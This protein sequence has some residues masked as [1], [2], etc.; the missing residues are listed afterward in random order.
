MFSNVVLQ[1][2]HD[3]IPT[4]VIT[5]RKFEPQGMSIIIRKQKVKDKVPYRISKNLCKLQLN[6][7]S[8]RCLVC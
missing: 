3:T 5:V 1:A 8:K 4:K 7:Q 2:V 6:D